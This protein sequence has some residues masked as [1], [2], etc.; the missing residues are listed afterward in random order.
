MMKAGLAK[1]SLGM[2]QPTSQFL[3][4]TQKISKI[5]QQLQYIETYPP[6]QKSG[7]SAVGM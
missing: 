3:T 2:G 7:L 6:V 5:T 1:W 4:H